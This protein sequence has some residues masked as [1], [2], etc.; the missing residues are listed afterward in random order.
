DRTIDVSWILSTDNVGVYGYKIWRDGRIVG[1]SL[2][3]S[4]SD[5]GLD[6]ATT[7]TYTISAYDASGNK[8]AQSTSVTVQTMDITAPTRPTALD[9]VAKTSS[10]IDL[11]WVPSLDNLA[12]AGYKIYRDG[13]QIGTSPTSTFSS[14]GLLEARTYSYT[15]AAYDAAGNTSS[16]SGADSATT[17]DVTA[18]SIPAGVTATPTSSSH[19][20]LAWPASSDNVG[21]ASYDVYQG[22]VL[23]G[24][25]KL[26]SYTAINLLEAHSY[27]FTVKAKD[28]SGN[29]SAASVAVT[30]TTFDVTK[31]VKP[32]GLVATPKSSTAIDLAWAPSSDNVA[33]TGYKVYRGTTQIA[34]T[35]GTTWSDSGLLEAKAYTYTVA[36]YDAAGNVSA[37]SRSATATTKDV[38]APSTPT[39]LRATVESS[40]K[41]TLTWTA[42]TDNL[43]VAGYKVYRNGV[44]LGTKTLTSYTDN[45]LA[46]NT[47]YTYTVAAYDDAGNTSAQSTAVTARTL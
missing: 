39:R 45:G 32:D 25:P 41:I 37:Q 9:A 29:V 42:A 24:S 13:A 15:V 14:T 4:F 31:P 11:T 34:S 10:S 47:S 46:R 1:N 21:V 8:S 38:T 40:S 19:I 43:K 2:T 7:H 17:L 36:A 20:E 12:V 35:T 27:T 16:Q 6:E 5:G 23:I 30:A 18:P 26:P 3:S 33:V 22:T 28:A 44:L